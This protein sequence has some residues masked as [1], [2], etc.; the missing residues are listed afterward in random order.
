MIEVAKE[1]RG[2]AGERPLAGEEYAS[3]MRN[4]TMRLPGRFETLDALEDAAI[5]LINYR[6]PDDYYAQYAGH[7]R[8]LSEADLD[9][10][11]KKFVR[12]E[13]AVW[14]VIGDLKKIEAGVRELGFGEIVR[15]DADGNVL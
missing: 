6:Y 3:I 1:L 8:K 12:P 9:A 11:S 15:I 5:D 14:V 10:A 13:E 4:Q 2:V 7:V